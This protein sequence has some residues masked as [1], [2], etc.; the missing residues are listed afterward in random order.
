[1]QLVIDDAIRARYELCIGL[2]A[3]VDVRP[4]AKEP[5]EPEISAVEAT[6]RARYELSTLKD[7]RV[8]RLQR[9]FFWHMGI[10][11]T[12]V[13]PASE[14][15]LRRI[16]MG[17]GLPRISPI[18]DAYNLASV[19][20]LLTFSVFDLK[21][22]VPPLLLRFA[23]AGET[24]HLIGG[25][26]KRLKGKEMVLCDSGK[27]LCVYVHGDTEHTKVTAATK[28]L[29][30]VAYGIPGISKSELGHGM[31]IALDYITRFAG[32]KIVEKEIVF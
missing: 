11:P 19:Q 3:I 26:L 16:L 31:E 27:I 24:V 13:R 30:L 9:D 18:V 28:D 32:G 10:D 25:R 2:A 4:V 12:K 21:R 23:H 7:I 6:L 29:L 22:I 8:L 15:L 20:T 17:R 14:A 1:M 5:L